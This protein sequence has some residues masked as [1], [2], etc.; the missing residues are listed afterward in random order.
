LTAATAV[1]VN[2]TIPI[3]EVE[4][5]D[6]FIL[7]EW[8]LRAVYL[9]ILNIT[10]SVALGGMFVAA[11]IATTV[12]TWSSSLETKIQ[13]HVNHPR[14]LNLQLMFMWSTIAFLS[15]TIL[16]G[17]LLQGPLQAGMNAIP[18]LLVLFILFTVHLPQIIDSR[19]VLQ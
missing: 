16:A 3:I 4:N 8:I 5:S 10:L 12:S 9:L 11:M 2:Q 15:L 6:N 7:V 19:S 18:L 14:I 17:G 13:W 1:T